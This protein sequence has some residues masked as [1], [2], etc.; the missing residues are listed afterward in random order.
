MSAGAVIC[1]VFYD[2]ILD[3]LTQPY[4][5]VTGKDTLTILSPLEGT[6]SLIQAAKRRT[7]GY[8]GKTKMITV[9]YL[10]AGEVRL[11][12]V[13]IENMS[14][15]VATDKDIV[16]EITRVDDN[17]TFGAA[18]RERWTLVVS[19]ATVTATAGTCFA[20]TT[21]WSRKEPSVRPGRRVPSVSG[22]GVTG[23]RR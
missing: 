3:Y 10:I 21:S 22:P 14:L 1:L 2:Y 17:D 19:P 7:R 8:R 11:L 9:I 20:T 4:E 23:R 6:N 13:A 15:S 16:T 5:H 12:A 18:R